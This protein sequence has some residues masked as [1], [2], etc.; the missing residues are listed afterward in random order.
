MARPHAESHVR[1]WRVLESSPWGIAFLHSSSSYKSLSRI[2]TKILISS[3]IK[4]KRNVK[5]P[6][7]WNSEDVQDEITHRA[8]EWVSEGDAQPWET[9]TLGYH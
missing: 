2:N 7:L 5:W 1:D 4:T 9:V 6:R 8:S 3:N